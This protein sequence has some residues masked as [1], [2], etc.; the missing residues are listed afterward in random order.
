MPGSPHASSRLTGERTDL[1]TRTPANPLF[2]GMTTTPAVCRVS[3]PCSRLASP[4]AR[5][6][7]EARLRGDQG[8]GCIDPIEVPRQPLSAGDLLGLPRY[9]GEAQRVQVREEAEVPHSG[10]GPDPESLVGRARVEEIEHAPH[11]RVA[12]VDPRAR[13]VALDELLLHRAPHHPRDERPD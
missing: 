2:R 6:R 13:E 12:G 1:H 5:R 4:T 7:L 10:P 9:Q 3:G 8:R 11:A